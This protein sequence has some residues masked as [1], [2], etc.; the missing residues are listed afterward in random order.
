M[1]YILKPGKTIRKKI[2][3]KRFKAGSG[4]NKSLTRIDRMGFSCKGLLCL[5]VHASKG[6]VRRVRT[7][8]TAPYLPPLDLKV[9][10]PLV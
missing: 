9:F 1:G 5:T 7:T 2:I 4:C 6:R 10:L 3:Q 8:L